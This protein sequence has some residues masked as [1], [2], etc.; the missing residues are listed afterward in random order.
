[1]PS[2]NSMNQV[3]K[4]TRCQISPASSVSANTRVIDFSYVRTEVCQLIVIAY[5]EC[6]EARRQRAYVVDGPPPGQKRRL[7]L[8]FRATRFGPACSLHQGIIQIA[9]RKKA[10]PTGRSH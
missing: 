5:G 7:L 9:T 2:K 4:Q 6:T 1:M 3:E 10:A 8:A